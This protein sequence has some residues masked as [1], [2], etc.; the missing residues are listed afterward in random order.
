MILIKESFTEAEK[1]SEAVLVTP[2]SFSAVKSW[3]GVEVSGID[4]YVKKAVELG[5]VK[6]KA[7]RK[8]PDKEP[9]KALEPEG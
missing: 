5:A 8:S 4:Y 7:K 2:Q 1:E 3:K 6:K 9:E